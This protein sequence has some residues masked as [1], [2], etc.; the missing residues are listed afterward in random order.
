MSS[1]IFHILFWLLCQIFDF[2]ELIEKIRFITR[3]WEHLQLDWHNRFREN[4]LSNL[5]IVIFQNGNFNLD[6]QKKIIHT[7]KFDRISIEKLC[8]QNHESCQT[9]VKLISMVSQRIVLEWL[10]K[11]N[12]NLWEILITLNIFR[13]N[14]E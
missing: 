9:F 3:P 7:L 14:N 2:L 1:T 10:K 13:S 6:P 5:K 12:G 4:G 8:I 11:W